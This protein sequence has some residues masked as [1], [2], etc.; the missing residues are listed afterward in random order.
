MSR[1]SVDEFDDGNDSDS[2]N[3][4]G[5]QAVERM[6]HNLVLRDFFRL[7]AGPRGF[8]RDNAADNA[9]LVNILKEL[10]LVRRCSLSSRASID[11]HDAVKDWRERC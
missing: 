10:N 3:E 9:E 8:Q 11:H 4:E 7:I 6:N 2:E 1:R 5:E